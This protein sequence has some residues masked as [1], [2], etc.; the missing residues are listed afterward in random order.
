MK[1][2]EIPNPI[3][4]II[5]D[6]CFKFP[7]PEPWIFFSFVTTRRR[8]RLL[9]LLRKI[10]QQHSTA[11][12]AACNGTSMSTLKRTPHFNCPV[13]KHPGAAYSNNL[14]TPYAQRQQQASFKALHVWYSCLNMR[15][16]GGT[17]VWKS[18]VEDVGKR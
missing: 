13:V 15:H 7:K 11:K 6:S 17:C 18:C 2:N 12:V 10:L 5:P 8:L 9:L 1:K 3:P 14:L 4:R 16:F